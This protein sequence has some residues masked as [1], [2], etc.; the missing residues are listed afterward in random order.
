MRILITLTL[1]LIYQTLHAQKF[2]VDT[3]QYTGNV[4]N[5]VNMVILAEGYQE[6]ELDKFT[7]DASVISDAIFKETPYKEYKD[8]FNVFIVKVISNE[9]GAKHPGTA[10][11]VNEPKHPVSDVDNYFGTSFDVIGIHRL[12]YPSPSDYTTVYDVLAQN[13]PMYDQ[14]MLLVN[15]PH[16]GGGGGEFAVLS[17]HKN[18]IQ[19]ALHELGHSFAGLADEYYAGDIY[20]G[21]YANMTAE[22][23][24]SSVRWGKWK[25][26]EGIGVYQHCCGGESSN[27][28][29]PHKTCKM[30][31]LGKP[32]CVVCR[33]A[34][35]L[36][37]HSLVSVI[38]DYSP[39]EKELADIT[40]PLN[41]SVNLLKPEPNSLN[42]EWFLNG[43]S[44]ELYTEHIQLQ[45]EDL[46]KEENTLRVSIHD[47]TEMMRLDEDEIVNISSLTWN[48]KHQVDV[49]DPPALAVNNVEDFTL[50]FYPN[51]AQDY[52]NI[53]MNGI[54]GK[55]G[56][57]QLFD[58]QGHKVKQKDFTFDN[59]DIP[60]NLNNLA[61][62]VYILKIYMDNQLLFSNK[63]V[64][65]GK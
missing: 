20:A 22:N 10:N 26:S 52:L 39:K 24:I 41:L 54:S 43:Q 1:C 3:L 11:D 8:F 56:Q 32:F 18:S 50:G 49:K 51:P 21:E 57:I 61:E 59:N 62:G 16:Y 64:K 29:Y 28:Y 14:V 58:T 7:N 30:K 44:L 42:I 34:T 36:T 46:N 12:L 6:N 9:S 53:Q 63:V 37:I 2:D 60:V 47:A 27:W 15:S 17:T 55:I 48:I 23:D 65:K 35:V 25:D 13:F 40:F 33:E 19:I 31:K 5:R 38:D 4:N 45:K